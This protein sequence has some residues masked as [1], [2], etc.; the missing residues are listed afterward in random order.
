M[1]AAS[2]CYRAGSVEMQD[3]RP[4]NTHVK[5]LITNE[6]DRSYSQEV[7]AMAVQVKPITVHR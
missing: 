6:Q 2:Y 4:E 7:V 5:G 3:V 1:A